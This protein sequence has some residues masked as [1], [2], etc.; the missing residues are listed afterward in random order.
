MPPITLTAASMDLSPAVDRRDNVSSDEAAL[1]ATVLGLFDAHAAG[2]RRYALSFGLP[3]SAAE[4]VVQE[5]YLTL[6][7]HL[8]L[9][10]P[11]EHLKGWLYRVT[12]NLS[13]KQRQRAKRWQHADADAARALVLI[14]PADNPEERLAGAE[15]RR[16]LR[17]V[18]QALAERDRRCL[19]LRAEGL[20]YRD[21]ARVLGVSLGSVAKSLTRAFARLA[22]SEAR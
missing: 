9:G 22:S 14:D 21:I 18:T 1:Q 10:R 17:A 5:A 6:F 4:D 3:P 13:L 11:R 15:R 2:L 7:A 12:H 8:R 16:R 19:Y 20:N